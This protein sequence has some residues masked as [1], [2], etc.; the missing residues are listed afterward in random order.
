M[1]PDSR[2]SEKT[3]KRL[4]V[5]GR[6]SQLV[7]D[8][9]ARLVRFLVIEPVRFPAAET[10]HAGVLHRLTDVGTVLL[11]GESGRSSICWT[12]RAFEE[13]PEIREAGEATGC[14]SSSNRSLGGDLPGAACDKD[15][16]FAFAYRT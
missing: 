16:A 14:A 8:L 9:V 11:S 3:S 12:R 13:L 1:E 10:V 5:L 2:S 15:K 4:L 7:G 6:F